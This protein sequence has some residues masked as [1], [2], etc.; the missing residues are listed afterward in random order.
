MHLVCGSRC[1]YSSCCDSIDGKE[2]QFNSGCRS[3]SFPIDGD[4][5]GRRNSNGWDVDGRREHIVYLCSNFSRDFRQIL[6]FSAYS[7]TSNCSVELFLWALYHHP[8]RC[9]FQNLLTG[10]ALNVVLNLHVMVN[11]IGTTRYHVSVTFGRIF[12]TAG[13]RM[14]FDSQYSQVGGHLDGYA[15]DDCLHPEDECQ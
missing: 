14:C 6:F 9:F 7:L 11:V 8:T 13:L 1:S 4:R 2:I 12:M 15:E 3:V 5:R 10:L